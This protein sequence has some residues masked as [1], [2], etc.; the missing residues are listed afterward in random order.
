MKLRFGIV[1]ICAVGLVSCAHSSRV[2]SP[3]QVATF[4]IF[5]DT[6]EFRSAAQAVVNEFA[7]QVAVAGGVDLGP[8]P[9]VQIR[10]TPQ[11]IFFSGSSNT[12]V[13]PWWASQ[14]ESMRS[15]F[16]HFAGAH[17]AEAEHFFRAFFNRFLLA[18][19]AAHWFQAKTGRREAPLYANENA[20]N[21]IAVAFWRTQPGGE[22]FLA[23]L[24]RLANHAA[25]NLTD[26]TP[27]GEDPVAYFG[28]NYQALGADPLKYGYYQFRFMAEALR[29][30]A[31]LDLAALV[32]NSR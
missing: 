3:F 12:I 20:A 19:E 7:A 21:R 13:A 5:S 27:T 8:A 11:L 31:R 26:P 32:K 24:E 28:A 29:D 23:E 4:P 22:A 10:N 17:G 16:G 6:T 2:S 30:R 18:H 1:V 14:P 15:V 25:A 9:T